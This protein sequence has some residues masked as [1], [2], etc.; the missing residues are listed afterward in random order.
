M[1]YSE[2]ASPRAT[3]GILEA[4][5]HDPKHSLGQNFLIDD[6]VIG[7]ILELAGLLPG[8]GGA[9]GNGSDA[10]AG[11][12]APGSQLPTVLEIGPGIGTLT[13]A[14]LGSAHVV[15]IERDVGLVPVLEETTALNGDRFALLRGDALDLQW[16]QVERACERLAAPLPSMLV[17]NLPYGIAATV[18]LDWFER[19]P[20]LQSM[21]VMVQSEVADRIQAQAGTKEYGAYTVKLRLRAR[22]TGRFQVPSTCFLPR[23]HVESSVLRLERAEVSSDAALV[24]RACELAD[25]AFAQRRKNI[26]NSMRSRLDK[27]EVDALLAAAGIDPTVRGETLS[28]EDFLR[29]AVTRSDNHF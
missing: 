2:L 18:I 8:E 11:A 5:G 23:P 24:A 1:S 27:R 28:P 26:R 12:L 14:L 15:A 6:N 17:S 19:F 20:R 16:E 4:Y 10:D 29:L 21:V 25:A 3:R 7:H 9:A 22:V 13:V